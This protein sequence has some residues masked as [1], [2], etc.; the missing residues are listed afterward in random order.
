MQ[1]LPL[2][3]AA[4]TAVAVLNLAVPQPSRANEAVP[5]PAPVTPD[6]GAAAA[7]PAADRFALGEIAIGRKR[8][9]MPVASEQRVRPEQIAE[10]APR[11]VGD[12]ARLIPGAHLPVNSRGEQLLYLR[13]A[14]E[15][16]V[17]VF[18]DGAQLM[19]PWDYAIDL[20][21]VPASL[22]GTIDVVKGASSV[23]WGANVIGGAVN[24]RTRSRSEDGVTTEVVAQGGVPTRWMGSLTHLGQSGSWAWAAAVNVAN[25]DNVALASGALAGRAAPYSNNGLMDRRNNSDSAQRSAMARGAYT[26]DGGERIAVTLLHMDSAKGAPPVGNLNPATN[27]VRYWRYPLWQNTAAIVSGELPYG[28]RRGNVIKA[29]AWVQR[30]AQDIDSYRDETLRQGD[31]KAQQRDRDLTF[32]YRLALQQQAGLGTLQVVFNH[33]HSAH[34]QTDFACSTAT[35]LAILPTGATT[36][37]IDASGQRYSQDIVSGGAEY[38]A[39][40]IDGRLALTAGG[41]YDLVAMG[42]I[43][44]FGTNAAAPTY[45]SASLLAGAR[46][47]LATDG[48]WYARAAGGHKSRFPTQ[49]ELYGVALGKFLPNPSLRPETA[50]LSEL[51]VG[52]VGKELTAEATLFWTQSRDTLDKRSVEVELDGV[53]VRKEQR[54]NLVGARVLGL[55]LV[56]SAQVVANLVVRGHLTLVDAAA[57][58]DKTQTFTA[59]LQRRPNAVGMAT[60]AWAP[61]AGLQAMVAA[62]H[63]GASY[64]VDA[65]RIV[66]RLPGATLASVRLAYRWTR[67]GK[68]T[69]LFARADNLL[70]TLLLPTDGLPEPGRSVQGGLKVTF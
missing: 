16:Q 19:V 35:C 24:L 50:L 23:L 45:S 66:A 64:S 21:M 54:H 67:A 15:R 25:N 37:D 5:L 69:E 60:V 31:L 48:S 65:S 61:Q 44:P 32:G 22:I 6:K 18:L 39:R 68:D 63:T 27:T 62:T 41:G 53:K 51:A 52:T 17:A 57:W 1:F 13:D 2:W 42:E 55:E 33:L 14:G 58:D 28:D 11:T 70:N 30:F 20:G 46:F 26:G 49:R 43:G 7:A 56:A 3:R 36:T 38:Q 29:T 10:L 12:L 4:L 59:R 47:N 8:K 40:L 9:P 34:R